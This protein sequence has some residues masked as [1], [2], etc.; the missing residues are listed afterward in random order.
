MLRLKYERLKRGISQT[1]LA[2]ITGIHPATLS[3]IENG[4][5][6]PYGGW[7]MKLAA[8]LGWPIEKAEE[9]FEEVE[10]DE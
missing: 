6:Y 9:L 1:K 2:A 3:K 7:R 4:R 5:I 8:A 10:R